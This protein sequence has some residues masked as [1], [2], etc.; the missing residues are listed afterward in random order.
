MLT[1]ALDNQIYQQRMVLVLLQDHES[2]S[3][4]DDPEMNLKTVL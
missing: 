3:D 1:F 4:S 2:D